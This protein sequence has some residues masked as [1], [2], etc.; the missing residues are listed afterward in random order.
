MKKVLIGGALLLVAGVAL[1]AGA[2]TMKG[3]D[4]LVRLGQRWA[5]EYMKQ[6]PGT[7][8]QVSGGGSGTGIAA[9]LNGST[10]IC[11]ASRDMKE[12][13]YQLAEKNGKEPFRVAVALDGI[14]VFLNAKNPVG[15][16]T[17]PQLKGIYTGAIVNWKEVGGPDA[18]IILYGRENN[19]GT[20]VFF[21]EHVLNDEDY[22]DRT[23]T[24]PGTAAVVN[25]VGKDP[26]GIGYG[27]LAWATGVKFAA[28][29][30]NDTAA[31]VM[32]SLE[33]VSD[34]R[35]PISRDLYWFFN[36]P[37]TGELKKL[38][39]WV[40]SPAGQ[41]MAA[42]IDYVPLPAERARANQVP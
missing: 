36:G 24:L 14:A 35:Y 30:Q 18:P 37:P 29:R 21:K 38:L 33:T 13:E 26:N 17:V 25:A 19:S 42:D 10:D 2:I 20:Y 12:K 7:V 9:L 11:Q 27:G 28:V 4:T 1:S 5:E 23:Q 6:N 3:S 40:L 15:E 41:T 34:G 39:N 8:I 32:P 16:L 22:A 31:A